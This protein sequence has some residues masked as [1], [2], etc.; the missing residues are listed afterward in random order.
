MFLNTRLQE[1]KT[2]EQKP[3]RLQDSWIHACKTTWLLNRSLQDYKP[4]EYKPARIQD[5]WTEA[6][7][8]Q[9]SWIQTC[10]NTRLL[11][12]SLQDCNT[13]EY[14]PTR[15]QNS[16]TEACKTTRLLNTRLE[17]CPCTTYVVT[18]CTSNSSPK[19]FHANKLLK[20]CHDLFIRTHTSYSSLYIFICPLTS[21]HKPLT[22]SSKATE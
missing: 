20:I 2:P 22:A 15:L 17:P 5:P 6:Y 21:R 12:R 18:N 4:P 10:K 16:W 9:D 3:A 11:N 8:T 7:K 1:Y 19:P 13:R 14:K